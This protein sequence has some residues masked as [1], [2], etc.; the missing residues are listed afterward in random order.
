MPNTSFVPDRLDWDEISG[1]DSL[2]YKLHYE[3]ALLGCDV[4]AGQVDLIMRFDSEGG[5][6]P[7]H[8][9]LGTTSV[10]VLEGEHH[11]T[12]LH[13][14]GSTSTRVRTTGTYALST[15]DQAPHLERGG[16]QGGLV[17]F[18]MKASDGHIIDL[19]DDDL[20]VIQAVTVADMAALFEARVAKT[21]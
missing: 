10:L 5:H 19:V 15:G 14:D 4:E 1:D 11:L 21:A 2:S 12:D 3:Y 20:N 16:P 18:S 7:R 9:H 17:F 13:P 6:C 8:R